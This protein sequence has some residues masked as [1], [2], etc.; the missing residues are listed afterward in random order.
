M[1]LLESDGDNHN[2]Q[3][4]PILYWTAIQQIFVKTSTGGLDNPGYGEEL[5][6]RQG[7]AEDSEAAAV[8]V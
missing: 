4:E 3:K 5:H 8:D 2:I 6:H 7:E 1:H